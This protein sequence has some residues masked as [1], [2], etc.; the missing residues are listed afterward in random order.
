MSV[1]V[2]GGET[3]IK[4]PSMVACTE[5]HKTKIEKEDLLALVGSKR[6]PLAQSLNM[7][8]ASCDEAR[9]SNLILGDQFALNNIP[10]QMMTSS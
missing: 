10:H 4:V 3:T 5:V 2:H 1:I 8:Y 7:K 9:S 6:F